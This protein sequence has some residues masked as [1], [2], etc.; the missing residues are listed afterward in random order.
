MPMNRVL[1]NGIVPV[2]MILFLVACGGK[3]VR[4]GDGA[5]DWVHR[6]SGAFLE[7][8]QK[9]FYGVGAITGVNNAPLARKA[10]DNRARAEISQMFE[11]YSAS[12]MRD[13]AASTTAGD[14][15]KTGEEQS[16]ESTIKTFSA[17]T[18]SGVMIIDHWNDPSSDVFYSLARLDL[19]KFKDHIDEARG[20][21]ADVKAFVKENAEKAFENLEKEEAK[22]R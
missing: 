9:A 14:L 17:T 6:G 2:L 10:A 7:N 4:V 5:P 21:N 8:D 11:T 18:L 15:K 22:R 3:G 13:Y 1:L 19:V 16:I 12:L 20:L